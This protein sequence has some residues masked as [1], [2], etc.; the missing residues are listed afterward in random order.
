[1]LEF[2][3][4]KMLFVLYCM[5]YVEG[6]DVMCVMFVKDLFELIEKVIDKCCDVGNVVYFIVLKNF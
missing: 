1:M 2:E 3:G 5:L 4:D 6:N